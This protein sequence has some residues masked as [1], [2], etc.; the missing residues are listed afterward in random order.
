MK[1][2]VIVGTII[3]T[4]GC[5]GAVTPA[6]PVTC[7]PGTTLAGDQCVVDADAATVDGGTPTNDASSADAFAAPDAGGPA[8]DGASGGDGGTSPDASQTS[9][10]CTPPVRVE[11]DPTCCAKDPQCADGGALGGVETGEC[12]S[13]T[14]GTG[15][16]VIPS[17]DFVARTPGNPGTDPQCESRCAAQGYAYGYGFSLPNGPN[18]TVLVSVQPPYEI[19]Q[20]TTPYCPD[21]V[22]PVIASGCAELSMTG[23]QTFY[24]MTKDPGAPARNIHILATTSSGASCSLDG[25]F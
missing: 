18:V 16:I 13:L 10:P 15:P 14:C 21:G 19:F 24:V 8:L 4:L 12:S 23:G 11:C 20:S 17:L 3:G 6:V 25:G 2:H 7:G 1:Q 9:D 22:H 5:S